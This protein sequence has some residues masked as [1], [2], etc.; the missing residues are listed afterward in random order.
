MTT[1]TKETK[2]QTP[3]ERRE[4]LEA[5]VEEYDAANDEMGAKQA[6]EV[7]AFQKKLDEH[8]AGK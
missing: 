4:E 1:Q 5:A 7:A 6:E 2:V 3:K 8:K